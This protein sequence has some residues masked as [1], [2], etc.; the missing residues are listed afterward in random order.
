MRKSLTALLIP[1]VLLA[2]L[3]GCTGGSADSDEAADPAERLA[4]AKQVI[5]E[6]ASIDVELSTQ[7][8]PDGVDGVTRATGTG[9]HDP[10]F[11]G[12]IDIVAAGFAGEA[13][14]VAVDDE[15]Y[16]QLPFTSEYV[17]V[18]VQTYGAPDPAVLMSTD[19]GISSLLTEATDVTEEG[20]RRNGEQVLTEFTGTLDGAVI[21]DL[22]PSADED[23]SFD[24]TFT[25]TDDNELDTA[26][27]TGPFYA[28]AEDVTYEIEIDTSEEP[29]EITA[30]Q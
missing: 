5:D 23:G 8:L 30:P 4:A 10:A 27:I 12:T 11:K 14:V 22:F 7:E 26:T 28:G 13:P 25:L 19:D 20:Q 2:L 15:V 24:V 29:V 16:V 3:V 6:A 1:A 17:P 18:D 21:A 9:N